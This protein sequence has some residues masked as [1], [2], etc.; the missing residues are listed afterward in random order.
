MKDGEQVTPEAHK[1]KKTKATKLALETSLTDDD[2][3]Q[4][5]ARL[6]EEMSETF[7]AI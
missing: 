1:R 5:A 7:Q 2:Y 6:K 3:E 4:V